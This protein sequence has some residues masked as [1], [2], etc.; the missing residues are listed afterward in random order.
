MCQSC[1]RSP[2]APLLDTTLTC[3]VRNALTLRLEGGLQPCSC[4]NAGTLTSFGTPPSCPPPSFSPPPPRATFLLMW[5]AKEGGNTR[6]VHPN[7]SVL[8]LRQQQSGGLAHQQHVLAPSGGGGGGGGVG[9][10]DGGGDGGR[11]RRE[12][13]PQLIHFAPSS[14]ASLQELWGRS[15][16]GRGAMPLPQPM[17]PLLP[18]IQ[19][20]CCLSAAARTV[21]RH[22]SCPPPRSER[23]S[24]KAGWFRPSHS[25]SLSVTLPFER[26]CKMGNRLRPL[27]LV[28]HGD[29]G[30][31]FFPGRPRGNDGFLRA[32]GSGRGVG[33]LLCVR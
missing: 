33:E 28:R 5:W 18:R 21:L 22:L 23:G 26:R 9:G 2:S 24:P 1:V 14:C 32:G 27:L 17:P 15:P 30:L 7:E 10:G 3:A 4:R 6:W 13:N 19:L 12:A 8:L 20:R 29:P 11:R 31:P 25:N 16:T